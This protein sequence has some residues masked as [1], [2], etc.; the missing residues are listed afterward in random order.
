MTHGT[1]IPGATPATVQGIQRATGAVPPAPT[2]HSAGAPESAPEFR[3]LLE[4]LREQSQSLERSSASPLDA[5]QLSGAVQD[6]ESSLRDA[7]SIADGLLEA[8]RSSL[9]RQAEAAGR[10]TPTR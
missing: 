9:V 4:R 2:S 6:A 5:R 1:S 8:Y 10:A 7:L 3:A